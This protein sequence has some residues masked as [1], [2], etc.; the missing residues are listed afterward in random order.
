MQTPA[1]QTASIDT[2]WNAVRDGFIAE[3]GEATFNN[4]IAPLALTELDS[5]QACISTPTRFTKEWVRIHYPEAL[6]GLIQQQIPAIQRIDLRVAQKPATTENVVS[7]EDAGINTAPTAAPTAPAEHALLSVI[8]QRLDPRFTFD[9]F[10]SAES[11]QLACAVAQKVANAETPIAGLNPLFIYG[12]VGL[13]KTHLLHAIGH[14]INATQPH[15]RVVYLSSEKFMY[16]FV[17]AL[18]DKD[19]MAFKEMFRSVDVLMIDDIQFIC[20]K[21]GTQEEF[22]HTFNALVD[23]GKQ[24]ILSADRS[25]TDMEGM[26]ERI[27]SRLGGGMVADIADTTLALRRGILASKVKQM[28]VTMPAEVLD[29]LAEKITSNVRE[30][31]GALNK[32]VAHTE[33][34]GRSFSVENTQTILCDLLRASEKTISIDDIKQQVA[35]HYQLKIADMNSARRAR[36]IARPRQIAMYLCKQ[37]TTHSF[38]EIGRRFGGKDHTTILHAVRRV[39]ELQAVEPEIAS[40]IKTLAAAIKRG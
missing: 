24:L 33:F 35:E 34:T 32:V 31:E 28:N 21:A 22:F 27:R 37:L 29:F 19:I 17:Q 5:H 9:H 18:R 3:F 8:G 10:V 20:G 25:P 4:W 40:D 36:H 16:Q 23:S 12:G 1:R 38:P 7:A 14:H 39:E 6:L 13:G 30:L 26:E 15:K 2:I 11:N